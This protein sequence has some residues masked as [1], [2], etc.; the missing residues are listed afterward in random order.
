MHKG[1]PR[2]GK[3]IYGGKEKDPVKKKNGFKQF[4]NT[5]RPSDI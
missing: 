2:R 3:C 4:H 5:P 1:Q